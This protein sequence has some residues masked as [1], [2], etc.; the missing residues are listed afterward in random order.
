MSRTWAELLGDEDDGAREAEERTGFFG[1]LR[2][3]LGKSRRALAAELGASFDPSEEDAWERLEV[4][5]LRAD[6]GVPATAELVGKLEARGDATDLGDALAEEVESLF[7]EPPVLAAAP[8]PPTVVLVV[9]VNGTGK[10]TTIGK[11][12]RV[13][14]EHGRSVLVAAADTFRAA[15]DEQLEIWAERAGADVVGGSRGADPA[16]VTF[17]AIE[18][19]RARGCDVVIVDTAGRLHTQGNL[20]EELAKVRRVIE[21]RVPGAPHETLLVVD[22]TTGQNGLQQA[23]LFSETAGVTGVALTKLDG[24]AKGGVAVA[25]VHELGLPVKL[26]GIGEGIEDLRPFDA[27]DYAR[28]LVRD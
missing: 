12:A 5:L 7:G 1:R 27:H 18:A 4:A 15:A 22:A 10:T 26:V 24:S 19:G 17:D 16:A 6:V 13:L 8:A 3:S 14:T 9:G 23:R 2:E 25:I 28:A 11:L 20:M 21:G